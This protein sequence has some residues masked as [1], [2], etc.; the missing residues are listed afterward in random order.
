MEAAC[1]SEMLNITRL[2]GVTSQKTG[3]FLFETVVC[4]KTISGQNKH[5]NLVPENAYVI[6][7][8]L[9]L[10]NECGDLNEFSDLLWT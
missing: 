9:E 10:C 7:T 8:S 3:I 4:V 6:L 2:H 1:S 5:G